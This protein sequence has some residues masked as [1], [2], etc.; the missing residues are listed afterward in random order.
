MADR[1]SNEQGEELAEIVKRL[2]TGAELE[3]SEHERYE[4]LLGLAASGDEGLFK[5]Q[6]RK[7]RWQ[8]AWPRSRKN[9]DSTGCA[10]GPCTQRS[11]R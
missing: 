9:S 11:G 1:L 6:R 2:R 3:E 4:A 8:N 10:G 7:M 5:Q